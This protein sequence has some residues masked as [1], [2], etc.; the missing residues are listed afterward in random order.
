MA[1]RKLKAMPMFQDALDL[2][3]VKLK[4]VPLENSDGRALEACAKCNGGG[5]V[6]VPQRGRCKCDQCSGAGMVVRGS[7]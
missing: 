7:K 5:Y 3:W 6:E 4:P 1:R 2:G